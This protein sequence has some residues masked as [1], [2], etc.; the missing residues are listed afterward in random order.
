MDDY[1]SLE[2]DR[3]ARDAVVKVRQGRQS[4]GSTRNYMENEGAV[5]MGGMCS[6]RFATYFGFICIIIS[7]GC[8]RCMESTYFGWICL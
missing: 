1:F 4:T 8:L 3:E 5:N 7:F 2:A 6:G